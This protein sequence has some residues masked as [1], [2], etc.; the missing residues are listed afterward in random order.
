VTRSE[1]FDFLESK[2][3]AVHVVRFAGGYDDSEIKYGVPFDAN[4]KQ[5]SAHEKDW[6]EL[7][8]SVATLVS[9]SDEIGFGSSAD[10]EG[11][12]RFQVPSR[13]ITITGRKQQWVDFVP[14]TLD[15]E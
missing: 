6:D 9:F 11:E 7:H 15:E 14:F 13:Q 12:A 1:I 5:I 10:I 8:T 2:G 4:D 3:V